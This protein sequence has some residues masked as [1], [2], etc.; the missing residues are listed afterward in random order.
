MH[1]NT[2]ST[3]IVF[4]IGQEIKINKIFVIKKTKKNNKLKQ[5]IESVKD[6]QLSNVE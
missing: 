6:S 4:R 2:S 1:S 5:V 3:S